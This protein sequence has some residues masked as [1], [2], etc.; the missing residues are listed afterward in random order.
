[1]SA[2][3]GGGPIHWVD[4]HKV[5]EAFVDRAIG[6][7]RTATDKGRPF[8]V[9]LWLDD[10]HTPVQ[11]PPRLRGDGSNKAHYLGVMM[12]MDRQLGRL[13]EHIRSQPS[14]R[15]NT[16][17]MLASD[18]GPE[19]GF[20]VTGG[21][22]GGKG[23]LY[24]GGIRSPLI[25]WYRGLAASAIGSTNERTVLAA[26]DFPPSVLALANVP[27]PPGVE[28]DGLNMAEV[29]IGR[30]APRRE[31]PIMWVRPP[32][33]PGPGGRWPDLAI[34][35]GDFKLLVFR[36][37]SKP[38]LFNLIDDPGESANVAARHPELVKRLSKT[39]IDWDTAIRNSAN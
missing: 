36:D 26:M 8:Y 19:S 21:L 20:G 1:M 38:E 10:V 6:E 28:F 14:L 22:R 25:V 15:D 9:N 24:E 13:F 5:T 37:S 30:S 17:I 4:R 12:E 7:I 2:E 35:D 34:R 11:P 3:L 16:I 31:R 33:R 29:L 27:A 39:V 18:N 32:D 23:M